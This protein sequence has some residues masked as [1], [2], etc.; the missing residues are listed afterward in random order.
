MRL[1]FIAIVLAACG[2]SEGDASQAPPPPQEA[3]A[4]PPATAPAEPLPA[5]SAH[6]AAP[7][8]APDPT[9]EFDAQ[10]ALIYRVAACA[11]A[12]A[13][14][15]RMQGT[16]DHH[17]QRLARLNERYQKRW[18]QPIMTFL[19]ELTPE[20]LPDR[21]IYPFGGEDLVSAL[22]AF[23]EASEISIISLEKGGDPRGLERL[24]DEELAENLER[25]REHLKFLMDVA[26]HR[27]EDLEKM[28]EDLLPEQLVGAMWALAVHGREPVTL[29]FFQV[30]DDGRLEYVTDDFDDFEITFR[31]PGGPLQTYRHM[32]TDLSNGGLKRAPGVVAYVEQRAP[33]VSVVKAA[34]FLL[35]KSYFSTIR[36][37]LL[38]HA[39]FI[40]SDATAPLPKHARAKGFEQIPY[41]T[42]G[43]PEQAFE[44]SEI[45]ASEPFIELWDAK[46]R[47]TVPVRWG[48]LD[49]K[50]KK[51]LLVSRKL[52]T[53]E[54]GAPSQ[55]PAKQPNPGQ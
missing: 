2:S 21:V 31:R 26:F 8:A 54:P 48:Y 10:G 22:A 50:R 25:S 23:P 4:A 6:D 42:F 28:A 17:C 24:G 30:Q 36:D 13:V 46:G 55:A 51:H 19:D 16:V 34:S 43:G 45:E 20:G 7:P 53:Q 33:F 15:A 14:P 35:W 44:G 29:R 52:P 40:V 47:G 49:T 5:S 38:D 41:G 27:T 12:A 18:L 32:A 1:V 11:G 39:V 3:P 9:G 37:L